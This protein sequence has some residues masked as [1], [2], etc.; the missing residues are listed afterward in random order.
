MKLTNKSSKKSPKY[1]SKNKSSKKPFSPFY[2]GFIWGGCFTLTATISS[3]L[4]I[5]V[6][7]KTPIN[8]NPFIDKIEAIQKF[9]INAFFTQQLEKPV[10]ILVMGIDAVPDD[11]GNSEN[12]FSGRSDTMLLVR[13][14]PDDNS[15]KL[16][17]IPRDS[18]VRFPHGSY[19]KINSANAIGGV[20]FTKEVIQEN[21]EGITIDKYI[22]VTTNAFK[23]L[24]D[25][26]GGVEVYVPMDMKYT[27]KTQGLYIDLKEGKQTLNGDEAEQFS[28]FRSDNLGDIGRVQRQQM[29]LKAL[30]K[31]LQSPQGLFKIPKA[32]QL[33]Q[34]EIDTDLTS[35]EIYNLAAFGL[36]V[37]KENVRMVMLPGRPSSR[38]EYR[39]SYWLISDDD[40]TR[41]IEEYLNTDSSVNDTRSSEQLRIS[42]QNST[43][44]GELARKLASFLAENGY[45]NVYVS[46][47]SS[48]P[49][50]VTQIISQ[51]GDTR[52]AQKI[53]DILNF[54]ELE[55]SS[56][57]DID[58]DI[59]IRVGNDAEKLLLNDTFVK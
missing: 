7:L 55:S 37:D 10:N 27:D 18:R 52:S 57:G 11:N 54:G 42:I 3:F 12:R 35:S 8:F 59:T 9:G 33:L 28:R 26:I 6:G 49:T 29:L 46:Q 22:R 2:Q 48:Y 58:S 56:T 25:L 1:Q 32:I 23:D 16:L 40:K 47:N 4:G 53:K 44:N 24:V 21:F 51:K 17:S 36:S 13:F 38:Q 39:L 19:D 5:T 43:S 15:L 50:S 45:N 14:Q 20:P 30:R 34:D 41:V 31:K